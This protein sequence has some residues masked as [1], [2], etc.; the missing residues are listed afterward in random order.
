[1]FLIMEKIRNILSKI[2][3]EELVREMTDIMYIDISNVDR[4][5]LLQD[6]LKNKNKEKLYMRRDEILKRTSENISKDEMEILQ[7][8]LN[9]IVVEL[10]KLK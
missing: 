10:S 2:Q 8:E 6:V 5:K 1:M 7:I 9:Q 4:E 3:D